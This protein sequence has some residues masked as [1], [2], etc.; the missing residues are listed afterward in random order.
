MSQ[1]RCRLDVTAFGQ[2]ALKIEAA[3]TARAASVLDKDRHGRIGRRQIKNKPLSTGAMPML[4]VTVSAAPLPSMTATVK[5]S[6]PT[7][8][9]CGV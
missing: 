7:K 3:R 8:P 1:E 2:L 4:I 6:F 5:L 9:D